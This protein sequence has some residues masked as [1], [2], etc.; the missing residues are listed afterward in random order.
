M[1][2]YKRMYRVTYRTEHEIQIVQA[3]EIFVVNDENVHFIINYL[4][5]IVCRPLVTS[6]MF[7]LK[8]DTNVFALEI[9]YLAPKPGSFRFSSVFH[10]VRVDIVVAA[11]FDALPVGVGRSIVT[12]RYETYSLCVYMGNRL[13]SPGVSYSRER[14]DVAQGDVQLRM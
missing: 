7:V 10:F 3:N 1:N 13:F 8:V 14:S 11:F 6:V 2:V 4:F 5:D 12:S 9:G